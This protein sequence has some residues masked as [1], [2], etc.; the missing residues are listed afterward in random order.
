MGPYF[1]PLPLES[2]N[3]FFPIAT[4]SVA[5]VFAHP[6]SITK[7][8]HAKSAAEAGRDSAPFHSA[9]KLSEAIKVLRTKV[10]FLEKL[11]FT[12][13]TSHTTTTDTRQIC[14]TIAVGAG[15][16]FQISPLT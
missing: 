2:I 8:S 14:A 10:I 11:K 7:A 16:Y 3:Q 15:G 4:R 13:L 9:L 5:F 12:S 6:E 1:E